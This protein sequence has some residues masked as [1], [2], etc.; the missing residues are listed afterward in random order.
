MTNIKVLLADDHAIL[1]GGIKSLLEDQTDVQ[2][3]GEAADGLEAI[4][5]VESLDPDIVIMDITMPR[6]SGLEATRS[7]KERF[8]NTRILVLTMHDSQDLFFQL[9]SVGASGYVLKEATPSELVG[10]LHTVFDGGIYVSPSIGKKLATDYLER[11]QA[12]E[13]TRSFG[14][15]SKREREVLRLIAEGLANKEIA[16]RLYVS[17]NTVQTHRLHIMRKLDLHSKAELMK[18]AMRKGIIS[19]DD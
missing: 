15:L 17:A 12:G 11:V 2:V 10:A 3:M 19:L 13:E 5:K 14:Q 16:D 9:L 1:R 18:Y 6:M 4:Q 8:P 7:I